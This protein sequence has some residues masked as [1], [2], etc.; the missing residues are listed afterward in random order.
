M[1]ITVY[2]LCIAAWLFDNN[3]EYNIYHILILILLHDSLNIQLLLIIWK[4]AVWAINT[5]IV[6]LIHYT[7]EPIW[8]HNKTVPS[9][10]INQGKKDHQGQKYTCWTFSLILYSTGFQ[11]KNFSIFLYIIC[12][13]LYPYSYS[14]MFLYLEHI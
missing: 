2:I 1:I 12:L 13:F 14:N 5:N 7:L 11:K 10:V 6:I 9:T 8:F 4:F 3:R